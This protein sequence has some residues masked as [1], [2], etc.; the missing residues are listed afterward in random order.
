MTGNKHELGALTFQRDIVQQ[1]FANL[2]EGALLEEVLRACVMVSFPPGGI[3][4]WE[5]LRAGCAG[6]W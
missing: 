2:E 3:V 1:Q 4:T 5:H 6:C